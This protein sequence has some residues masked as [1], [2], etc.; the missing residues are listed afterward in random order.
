MRWTAFAIGMT[1]AALVIAAA[2][3][4]WVISQGTDQP[5][6]ITITVSPT[7]P[8]RPVWWAFRYAAALLVA[9]VIA[10]AALTTVNV[11]PPANRALRIAVGVVAG[12]EVLVFGVVWFSL[13]VMPFPA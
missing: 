11:R 1:V 9:L 12:L 10:I 7:P 13:V 2:W 4:A 8:S 3:M 5:I 6:T